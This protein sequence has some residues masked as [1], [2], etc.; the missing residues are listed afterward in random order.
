MAALPTWKVKL[1]LGV[2]V[3]RVRHVERGT[4]WC[5]AVAARSVGTR[6]RARERGNVYRGL[7][8]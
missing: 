7:W 6:I 3:R 8:M 5:G 4:R 1:L 2:G